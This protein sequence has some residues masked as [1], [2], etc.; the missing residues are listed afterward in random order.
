M[1]PATRKLAF[2][3]AIL[4]VLV[5]PAHAHLALVGGFRPVASEES[6]RAVWI[7]PAAVGAT[8]L[9]AAAVELFLA[10]PAGALPDGGEE[11]QI[12][13]E[14]TG[15]S[16]AA[17]TD[18]LAYGYQRE[19]D[20]QPGV[21]AWTLAVANR[22][23]L[24]RIGDLG[25]G[26]EWRGGSDGGLDGTAGVVLPAG[27]HL[28]MAAVLHEL[29]ERGADGVPGSRHWQLGGALRLAPLLSQVTYDA[30]LPAGGGDAVH[31][32]GLAIDRAKF[33]HVSFA[34]SSEGDWSASLDLAFPNH[35]LGIG[36]LD[37]DT[38]EPRPD[39]AYFAAEWRGRSTPGAT[40]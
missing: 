15:F 30:L 9:G 33:A 19:L 12:P 34:R 36:A 13:S 23:P 6:A 35:L 22:V 37:R 24:G 38:S 3:L 27:R 32:I 28:R 16:V 40:R 4:P 1:K 26:L 10:D 29:F 2:P 5:G 21:P 31:W 7:N 8:G 39:R 17:A 18:K 20:D 25:A 11:W 14:L